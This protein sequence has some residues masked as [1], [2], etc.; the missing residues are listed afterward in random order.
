MKLTTKAAAVLRAAASFQALHE[1]GIGARAIASILWANPH[2]AMRA[3]QYAGKLVH[4]NWL[5]RRMCW[6]QGARGHEVYSHTE[7]FITRKGRQVLK[8]ERCTTK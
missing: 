5:Q 8:G 4:M 2:K 3:G 1:G 7:Y 6:Y